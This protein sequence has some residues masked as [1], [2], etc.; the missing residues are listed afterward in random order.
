V[1]VAQCLKLAI[2]NVQLVPSHSF[3]SN[4]IAIRLNT[5]T[6]LRKSIFDI[7]SLTDSSNPMLPAARGPV[8]LEASRRTDVG[9]YK[10][11]LYSQTAEF[12]L[13][14]KLPENAK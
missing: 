5:H 4:N 11:L 12:V 3:H 8:I 1:L 13:Q 7:G 9:I 14:R 10:K 6:I 2:R